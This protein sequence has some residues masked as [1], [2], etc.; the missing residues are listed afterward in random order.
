MSSR[1]L[2]TSRLLIAPH[3]ATSGDSA[4]KEVHGDGGLL[5]AIL[6][7]GMVEAGYFWVMGLIP[8]RNIPRSDN[9]IQ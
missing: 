8:K 7:P 6:R 4:G 5:L 3:L 2:T 9:M 1:A